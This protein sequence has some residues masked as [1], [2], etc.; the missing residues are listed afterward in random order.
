[1][2]QR[3][4]QNVAKGA[5]KQSSFPGDR[6]VEGLVA[7]YLVCLPVLQRWQDWRTETVLEPRT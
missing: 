3:G 5:I 6:T 4:L 2:I 1:M 7:L